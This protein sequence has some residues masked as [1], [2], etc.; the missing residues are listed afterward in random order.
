MVVVVVENNAL[1][2]EF[3][4]GDDPPG[5]VYAYLALCKS[6]MRSSGYIHTANADCDVFVPFCVDGIRPDRGRSAAWRPSS[7]CSGCCRST[8]A[9]LVVS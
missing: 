3:D 5:E 1:F 6:S 8:T 4:F 7:T 2:H 9:V